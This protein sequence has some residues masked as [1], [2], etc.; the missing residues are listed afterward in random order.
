MGK[1]VQAD[2][3][4]SIMADMYIPY[5]CACK[6]PET[7]CDLIPF[8]FLNFYVIIRMYYQGTT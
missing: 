7:P 5:S 4:K 1:W 6:Q 8:C 2:S 3:Q